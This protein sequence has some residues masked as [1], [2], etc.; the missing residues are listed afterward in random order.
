MISPHRNTGLQ[1]ILAGVAYAKRACI[2]C[3]VD[4]DA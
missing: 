2:V 1:A 4:L 3:T